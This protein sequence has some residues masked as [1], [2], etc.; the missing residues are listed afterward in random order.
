MH[1]LAFIL[2]FVVGAII[3]ACDGDFSGVIA[4]GKFVGGALLIFGMLWL[5]TQPVLLII[6]IIVVVIII[7]CNLG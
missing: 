4:I 6:A 7:A 3:A 5:F 1:I 2:M